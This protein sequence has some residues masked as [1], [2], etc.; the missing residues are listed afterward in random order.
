MRFYYMS[1]FSLVFIAVIYAV[2]IFLASKLLGKKFKGIVAWV[3]I[4]A[5]L[6]APWTEELWIAYNFGQLCRKDAGIFINKTVEVDGFYD[7]TMRSAYENTKPGRYRFVEHA[8]E[9]RHGFERVQRATEEERLRALAWYA[10]N[11]PGK[12]RPKDRSIFQPLSEKEVVAV[13]PNDMDAWRITKLDKPTARYHY[14]NV[15]LLRP[16]SHQIDRVEDVV[17]DVQTGDVL[18]RYVNYYRGPY[19]FFIHLSRPTIPC[20][21]TQVAT[22]KYGS[23]IYP[24]V[25]IPVKQ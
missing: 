17:V 1:I 3:V 9:D 10:E 19:W 15:D 12:G 5:I 20:E 25:L 16:V 11:N 8:T 24:K 13:L 4:A 18:G 6:I 22:R 2:A 7:S 23:L 14:R 21:E